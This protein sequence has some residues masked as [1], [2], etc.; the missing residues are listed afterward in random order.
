MKTCEWN[1]LSKYVSKEKLHPNE[2]YE[3]VGYQKPNPKK[4]N[5]GYTEDEVVLR[6]WGKA[7]VPKS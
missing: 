3:E 7:N 5:A 4:G 6:K 1:G 2:Y